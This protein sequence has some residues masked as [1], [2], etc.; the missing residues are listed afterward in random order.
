VNLVPVWHRCAAF[1]QHGKA[2]LSG[3]FP[4]GKG[5]ET[6]LR[7]SDFTTCV[8]L[9]RGSVLGVSGLGTAYPEASL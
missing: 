3:I 7:Y 6:T 9:E 2:L 4:V 1:A 5:F 8:A